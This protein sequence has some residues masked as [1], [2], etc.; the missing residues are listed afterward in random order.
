MAGSEG[1]FHLPDLTFWHTQQLSLT[2]QKT[3]NRPLS[4]AAAT[5]R[6]QHVQVSKTQS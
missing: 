5:S 1:S 4:K 6:H 3:G 2:H